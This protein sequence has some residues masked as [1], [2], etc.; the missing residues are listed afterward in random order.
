MLDRGQ[1]LLGG[2]Q[3]LAVKPEGGALQ[4]RQVQEHLHGVGAFCGPTQCQGPLERRRSLAGQ[5]LPPAHQPQ[6]PPGS[7]GGGRF[8]SGHGGSGRR[9]IAPGRLE[10]IPGQRRSLAEPEQRREPPAVGVMIN[11]QIGRRSV[12]AG[13]F[14]GGLRSQRLLGGRQSVGDAAGGLAGLHEVEDAL[15]QPPRPA[16]RRLVRRLER[17]ADGSVQPAALRRS[18]LGAQRLAHLVM[19]EGEAPVRLRPHEVRAHCVEEVLLDLVGVDSKHRCEHL[20]VK[21]SAH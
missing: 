5:L 2:R 13:R 19:G 20:H 11:Q 14:G 10:E 8:T 1:S 9:L 7:R 12:V 16:R 4:V 21:R 18:D 6:A 3:A 17:L 15:R